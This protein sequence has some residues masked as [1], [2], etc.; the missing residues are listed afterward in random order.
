MSVIP[1]ITVCILHFIENKTT[2]NN[3]RIKQDFFLCILDNLSD[4]KY[5]YIT[6]DKV[7]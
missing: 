4:I 1:E 2:Q 3:E 5:H 6:A 7:L